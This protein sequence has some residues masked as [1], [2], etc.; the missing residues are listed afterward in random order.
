MK[1]LLK[2][3]NWICLIYFTEFSLKLKPFSNIHFSNYSTLILNVLVF[4]LKKKKLKINAK[5]KKLALSSYDITFNE[6]IKINKLKT[7]HF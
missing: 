5:V 3:A 1:E 4:N 6:I 7:L 2:I